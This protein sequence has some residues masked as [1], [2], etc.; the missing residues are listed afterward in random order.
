MDNNDTTAFKDTTNGTTS[1]F[2]CVNVDADPAT[3]NVNIKTDLNIPTANTK[4]VEMPGCGLAILNT[5][6]HAAKADFDNTE[7]NTDTFVANGAK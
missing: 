4:V 3:A 5:E 2:K 6:A 7:W 1:P